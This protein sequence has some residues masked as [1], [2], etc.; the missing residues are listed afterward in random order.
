M[1]HHDRFARATLALF[2]QPPR[3][4]ILRTSPFGDSAKFAITEFSEVR[5]EFIEHSLTHPSPTVSYVSHPETPLDA[6]IR[7]TKRGPPGG[8]GRAGGPK[9]LY[10]EVSGLP[11][12]ST[13]AGAPKSPGP[14]IPTP[15]SLRQSPR[16]TRRLTTPTDGTPPLARSIA[17]CPNA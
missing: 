13:G 3:I 2:T 9:R 1:H 11:T 16:S 5:Q 14:M 12:G 8:D 10:P 7:S 6:Y 17:L 15:T 4:E